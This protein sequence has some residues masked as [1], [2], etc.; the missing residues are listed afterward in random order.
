MAGN[1]APIRG[2]GSAGIPKP[3]W[4]WRTRRGDTLYAHILD[5]PIGPLP[6]TGVAAE[7]IADA[8]EL[9]TGDRRE[10][11]TE[12]V[13]AAYPDVTFMTISEHPFFTVPA[14]RRGGHRAGDRP[15]A[16]QPAALTT[17]P[18]P[19]V[20]PSLRPVADPPVAG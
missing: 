10:V 20:R 1:G 18:T 5:Q 11:T 15:G 14:D 6:L 2:C 7:Q 13:T 12:W 9:V 19:A 16:G 3:D 17:A 4:G 8:R